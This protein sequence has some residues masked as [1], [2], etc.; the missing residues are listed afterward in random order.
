MAGRVD[1]GLGAAAAPLFARI[2]QILASVKYLG[3]SRR[4]PLDAGW[5]R[6]AHTFCAPSVRHATV[7]VA[8]P[9][10]SEERLMDRYHSH[11]LRATAGFLF[12]G[13]GACASSSQ[14]MATMS[15]AAQSA[16]AGKS[17][18]DDANIFALLH[19]SNMGEVTAGMLAQQRATDTAVKAFG[20]MMVTEHSA[21]DQQGNALAQQLGVTP[22]LP[23]STLPRL[24]RVEADSL[25]AAT[26]RFDRMYIGQQII[27]H[28]RT[29]DLVDASIAM[30]Q[31]AELKT[32]LQQQVR[33]AVSAHLAR[34]REIQSRI[35]GGGLPPGGGIGATRGGT[36]TNTSAGSVTESPP[37][38]STTPPS[39]TTQKDTTSAG[40][41]AGSGK[42]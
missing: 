32:A 24:Q 6:T 5:V 11:R 12:A 15:P 39:G 34:A 33:P 14:T 38:S 40:S 23:D 18:R 19:T 31:H 3:W 37:G 20:G 26:A 4:Q 41:A 22:A 28:Q 27:A 42:P 16:Q 9:H 8:S 2:T 17:V 25:R 29:L 10:R 36:T 30:A 1:D 21:L 7:A 13:L 35:G